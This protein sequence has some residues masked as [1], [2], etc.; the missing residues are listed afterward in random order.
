MVRLLYRVR[1]LDWASVLAKRV[2]LGRAC[3][4]STISPAPVMEDRLTG[5]RPGLRVDSVQQGEPDFWPGFSGAAG[6]YMV[7][8]VFN[9]DPDVTLPYQTDSMAGVLDYPRCACRS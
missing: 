8:E 3:A 7:G 6:V 9:G 5:S 2:L 4:L 1:V